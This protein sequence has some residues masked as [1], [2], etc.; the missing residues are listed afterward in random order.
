MRIF[1]SG[2][3]ESQ[4]SEMYDARAAF[5]RQGQLNEGIHMYKHICSHMCVLCMY[6]CALVSE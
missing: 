4:Y 3:S 6:V 2:M 1:C 5:L